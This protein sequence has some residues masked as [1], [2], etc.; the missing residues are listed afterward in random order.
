MPIRC[1]PILRSGDLSRGG[2]LLLRSGPAEF[3]PVLLTTGFR[4]RL[5]NRFT[6]H[7]VVPKYRCAADACV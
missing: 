1:S 3:H 7:T 4:D 6:R 2:V 5:L